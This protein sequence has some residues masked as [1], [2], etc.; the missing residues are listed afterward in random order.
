[1]RLYYTSPTRKPPLPFYGERWVRAKDPWHRDAFPDNLKHAAP[2]KGKRKMGWMLED[3]WENP[4]GFVP[5]GTL[6]KR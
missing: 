3:Y 2:R 4:I 5:D 1:M 6:C